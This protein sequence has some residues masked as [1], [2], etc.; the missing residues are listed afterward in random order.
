MVVVAPG[1]ISSTLEQ[2]LD[3][4]LDCLTR[5]CLAPIGGQ[6]WLGFARPRQ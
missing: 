6:G 4:F 1:S 3:Q 5:A 2:I